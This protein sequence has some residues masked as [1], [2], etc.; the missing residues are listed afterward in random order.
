MSAIPMVEIWRGDL[1][2]EVHRGHAVIARADGSVEMAWGD[3]EALIYPRSSCKI[4]Q[5]LP[6]VESGAADAAGLTDRH[7]ALACASHSG[8]AMH[9]TLVA[10][11]IAAIGRRESDLRCGAHAPIDAVARDDLVRR[12]K[13]P[14]QF[15]NNCSGKHA[16]FLTLAGHLGAGPD[17]VAIDHPVQK[18]ART[19]FEE[20]TGTGAEGWGIDGCSAPNFVTSVRGLAIAMARVASASSGSSLR[21]GAATR[22]AEA[23]R[24]H[25]ELVSGVGRS[26]AALARASD[27][28]AIVK[29]GGSDVYTAILPESGSGIAIKIVDGSQQAVQAALAALLVRSGVLDPTHPTARTYLDGPLRNWRGLEVGHIRLADGFA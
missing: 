21:H 18:A 12:G 25:P 3:T 13:P 19:A 7:L 27:G 23:M 6:L 15:H 1:A 17:Y 16:G 4:L 5:A 9:T 20:M 2:E 8:A 14:C 29:I 28:R 24:A 11:W 22:L 26:C 10:D